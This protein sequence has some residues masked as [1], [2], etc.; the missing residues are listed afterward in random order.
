VF[1]TTDR[2]EGDDSQPWN[3]LEAAQIG[4]CNA[5]AKLQRHDADQPAF[6]IRRVNEFVA[7]AS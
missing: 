2:S 3:H 6:S 1:L 4:G 7:P 5:V